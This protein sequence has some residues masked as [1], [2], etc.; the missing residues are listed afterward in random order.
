MTIRSTPRSAA[1]DRMTDAVH[2]LDRNTRVELALGLAII[3]I[4]S[5]LGLLSPAVHMGMQM[6]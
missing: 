3:A 1:Y 2:S 6:H 4:V 5:V